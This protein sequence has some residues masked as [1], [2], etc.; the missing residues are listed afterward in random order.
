MYT[1]YF[2][3]SELKK[4]RTCAFARFIYLYTC[5]P[6]L[7]KNNFINEVCI[8]MQLLMNLYGRS[9]HEHC[10]DMKVHAKL[11]IWVSELVIYP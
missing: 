10:C 3:Q 8:C 2:N 1:G 4:K 6:F 11:K 9:E 5:R 7:S